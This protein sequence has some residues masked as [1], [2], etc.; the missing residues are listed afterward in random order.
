MQ[1]QLSRV[2]Q[3][4]WG[5]Q[6]RPPVA[7]ET[8]RSTSRRNGSTAGLGGRQ[9]PFRANPMCFS[10]LYG[11]S[12]DPD[13]PVLRHSAHFHKPTRGA[14][15]LHWRRMCG[16]GEEP[17]ARSVFSKACQASAANTRSGPGASGHPTASG[18]ASGSNPSARTRE[19]AANPSRRYRRSLRETIVGV[20]TRNAT[21]TRCRPRQ[22][23]RAVR[24]SFAR[25]SVE[26]RSRSAARP[27]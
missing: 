23:D 10:A 15:P 22:S 4:S 1:P 17:R 8:S 18:E 12:R 27:T 3:T 25:S 20:R 26:R 24:S 2:A 5:A 16:L 11:A 21:Y 7:R 19:V 14:T 9:L 13:G 6:S